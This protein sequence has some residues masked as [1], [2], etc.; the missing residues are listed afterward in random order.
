MLQRQQMEEEEERERRAAGQRAAAANTLPP[1]QQAALQTVYEQAVQPHLLNPTPYHL[2]RTARTVVQQQM[3]QQ[4]QQQPYGDERVF[5]PELL[6]GDASGVNRMI[7]PELADALALDEPM[8]GAPDP[9]ASMMRLSSNGLYQDVA[10]AGASPGNNDPNDFFSPGSSLASS[11]PD[12][13]SYQVSIN[14]VPNALLYTAID[15]TDAAVYGIAVDDINMAPAS[16]SMG[17]AASAVIG[18]ERGGVG[19]TPAP[20]PA[21]VAASARPARR[22]AAMAAS[23][24]AVADGAA[25][26][27]ASAGATRRQTGARVVAGGRGVGAA[28]AMPGGAA[29]VPAT[30]AWTGAFDANAAA[31]GSVP[32]QFGLDAASIPI[33]AM[34]LK[35]PLNP[36]YV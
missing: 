8:M 14:D 36:E 2:Q 23:A 26:S 9:F 24:A 11:P 27:G 7:K 33:G 34:D 32:L 17:V 31:L 18:T 28:T 15:S 1:D 13:H 22:A 10:D 30:L 20:A 6:M 16:A 29:S 21:A 4:Q 3:Q 5:K 12:R 25:S 19:S 35:P